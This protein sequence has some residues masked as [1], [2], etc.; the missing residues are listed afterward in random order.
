MILIVSLTLIPYQ[1]STTVSEASKKDLTLVIALL[2]RVSSS[3]T[4]E[5][6]YSSA[7][8]W[9][10]YDHVGELIEFLAWQN[11]TEVRQIL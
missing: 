1:T 11:G 6:T 4:E 5:L 7:N 3:D 9:L 8:G 10:A 2:P